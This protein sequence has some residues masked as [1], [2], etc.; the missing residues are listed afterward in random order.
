[1]YLALLAV[2]IV[3]TIQSHDFHKSDFIHSSN[4]FAG[5]ILN[6]RGSVTSYFH[7]QEQNDLLQEENALLRMHLLKLSDTLLGKPETFQVDDNLPFKIYP[8]RVIKNSY[9]KTDNFITIDI[10]EEQGIARD[11]GVMTHRGIVG[12][13]DRTDHFTRVASILNTQLSI[14]AQIKGTAIIGS[15]N[16]DGVDPYTITL[17]DVP[18]LATVSIG[19]TITTGSQSSTF[20][21]DIPIG[22][23]SEVSKVENGALFHIQVKLFNDMTNL[24]KVYVVY[25]RDHEALRV[26]D[27]LGLNE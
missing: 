20:P 7:L 24:G 18:R 27:T 25:S 17:K 12:V 8:A 9:D 21:P 19:D 10:G 5:S 3:F 1:M 2:T 11:M 13:V 26:I 16:W 14:N 6:T 23:V 4:R 22:E 15:L